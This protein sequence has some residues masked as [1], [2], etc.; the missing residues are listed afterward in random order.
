[1]F[2]Y[3]CGKHRIEQE[4][5]VLGEGEK[6]ARAQSHDWHSS[7]EYYEVAG[8]VDELGKGQRSEDTIER[9][10]IVPN[11]CF[12]F[13]EFAVRLTRKVEYMKFGSG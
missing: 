10:R 5:T 3:C 11:F 9:E 13:A 7:R 8:T 2:K 1:M 12:L 4:S 6:S